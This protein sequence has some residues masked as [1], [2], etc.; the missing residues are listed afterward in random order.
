MAEKFHPSHTHKQEKFNA[1]LLAG[2]N[3]GNRMG[4]LEE[5]RSLLEKGGCVVEKQSLA[6]QTKAWGNTEQDDFLNIAWLVS[7]SVDPEK[8]LDLILETEERLGR[9][10]KVKWEPRI[11]DIDILLYDD[12]V[13]SSER[14]LIPHP[15]LQERRFAL[16]PA[17]S[18]A[19][20]WKHPVLAKTLERL[21]S[22]CMDPLAV[23]PYKT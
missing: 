15:R 7:T 23:T 21:L 20:G 1:L 14:L 2:S 22:E 18:I 5:A 16:L 10:R 11:I 12:R 9:K 13:Y 17:A 4:F 6:F 3:I 19:P 8:L